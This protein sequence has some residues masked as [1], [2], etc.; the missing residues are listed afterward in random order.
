MALVT[1]NFE[2][3]VTDVQMHGSPAGRR[4]LQR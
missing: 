3:D 4:Y 1:E 2:P